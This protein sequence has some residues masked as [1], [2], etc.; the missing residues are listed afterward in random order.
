MRLVW[1]MVC[2]WCVGVGKWFRFRFRFRTTTKHQIKH[3]QKKKIKKKNENRNHQSATTNAKWKFKTQNRCPKRTE[4]NIE[5]AN[6]IYPAGRTSSL[7]FCVANSKSLV[8]FGCVLAPELSDFVDATSCIFSS[9]FSCSVGNNEFIVNDSCKFE[10][11]AP[12][13]SHGDR[14]SV[15]VVHPDIISPP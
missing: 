3:K 6:G 9:W 14:K 4:K 11:L 10:Q 13:L 8:N 5:I 2:C 1:N 12:K 7:R 15:A